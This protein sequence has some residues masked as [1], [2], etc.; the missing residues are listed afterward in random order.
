MDPI[1]RGAN[2]AVC[3]IIAKN[4]LAFAR[5]LAQ[6]FLALHPDYRFFVLVVDDYEGF[7]KPSEECFDI[8]NMS[9]LQIEDLSSFCF[10]YDVTELCTAAKPFLL[11]F[12]L[13]Q[14]SVTQLLYLDPDILVTNRLNELFES[15]NAFDIVLTPHLDV[16]FPD[17]DHS[18]DDAFIMRAGVFNLGFIGINSGKNASS[19]LEWW[20]RKLYDKCIADVFRGYF[21]DQ[22][23]IDLVPSLFEN[24]LIERDPGY[25]VAYWNL[26]S[27]SISRDQ[28]GWKCNDGMLYFYHFSGYKADEPDMI[29]SHLTR[30][31]LRDR[32][33]LQ[34]LFSEYRQLLFQ[35]GADQSVKW[36]YTFNFFKTGEP[37]LPEQRVRYRNSIKAGNT[38]GDPFESMPLKRESLMLRRMKKGPLCASLINL[39]YRCGSPLR[40][41]YR[42]WG[43]S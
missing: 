5:S 13:R 2:R 7:I 19:F 23:F 22:K 1:N 31:R 15:L 32:P 17:D 36:Q 8:I 11:D 3:T 21:V 33:D 20:K 37:I 42:R 38:Y 28:E 27:R 43:D 30:Y 29:S 14:K 41:L 16:D 26:H 6:S 24:Y 9:D 12:L 18:P 10:K 4:Y 40:A 35:N 34:P 39:G 25:N